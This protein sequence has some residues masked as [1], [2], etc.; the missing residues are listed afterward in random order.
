MNQF[1]GIGRLTKDIEVKQ[2]SSGKSVVKF[3]LAINNPYNR[4]ETDFINCV[5][6][7]KKADNMAKFLSKGSQVGITGRLNVSSYE[8][9]N[10]NKVWKTEVIVS[11]FYLIESKKT[12]F[13]NRVESQSFEDGPALDI[14]SDDFDLPF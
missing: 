13:D 6:W 8:D 11:D 4:D 1:N 7:E 12:E 14:S 3:T 5:V 2:T 10:G 9:K